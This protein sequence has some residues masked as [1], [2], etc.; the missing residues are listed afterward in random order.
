VRVIADV[1]STLPHLAAA[2]VAT[3][4]L[5]ASGGTRLKILEAL[6]TGTPVVATP[7]GAMGLEHLAGSGL[8]VEASPEAFAA[9]VLRRIDAPGDPAAIRAAVEPYR[10]TN[11]LQ[12][13]L[14]AAAAIAGNEDRS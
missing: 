1:P 9:A 7:L 14:G 12:P 8:D 4:P 3:A 13:L 11:A 5:Q 2:T 10:W 6:A